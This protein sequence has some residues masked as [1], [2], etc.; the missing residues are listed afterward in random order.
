MTPLRLRVDVC[1][2]KALRDG[3]PGALAAL[4]AAGVRATFMVAFGP[5][6]SGR[7][8]LKM[9]NPSFALKV[10]RTG[11]GGTYG[12]ASAFY[13][14]LLPAPLVGAGL[15][16]AVR[17][18][19]DEGHEVALHGWDHRRW[20]DRLPRYPRERLRDEFRQMRDAAEAILGRPPAGF[21]APAWLV[22]ADLLEL[23]E[24]AGF[25][26]AGDTRGHA[27][28]LPVLDGR[29]FR[30]PQLPVTLPT[31]DEALALKK[32][33]GFVDEILRLSRSQPEYCCLAAHAELEGLSFRDSFERL[34]REIGRPVSPVGET[35]LRELPRRTIV[36]GRI[37]G[38]S[39][40]MSLEGQGP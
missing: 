15:P 20:Q 31:L 7:A 17:R 40:D 39:Y 19:R 14:T 2:R 36:L 23:E 34:L 32:G 26:W 11:G 25:Q 38:R 12:W 35:P 13:G 37:E 5:D 4:R 1:T 24:E 6:T 18:I 28:Y 9:L 21:G 29:P 22:S 8:L 3:V 16:D 10:L 30:V 27:P 33:Q